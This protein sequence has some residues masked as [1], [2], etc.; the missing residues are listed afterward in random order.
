MVEFMDD[1][2]R[3]YIGRSISKRLFEYENDWALAPIFGIGVKRALSEGHRIC[4]D[5]LIQNEYSYILKLQA[6]ND[7]LKRELAVWKL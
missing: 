3:Y 1:P 7:R 6:E 2:N 5:N 4:M